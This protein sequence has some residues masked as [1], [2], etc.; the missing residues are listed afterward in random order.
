MTQSMVILKKESGLLPDLLL[1]HYLLQLSSG[2]SWGFFLQRLCPGEGKLVKKWK[3]EEKKAL[4][5]QLNYFQM[6]L[7][8]GKF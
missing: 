1:V 8:L 4:Q 3:E 2:W 7:V 5:Q 6:F